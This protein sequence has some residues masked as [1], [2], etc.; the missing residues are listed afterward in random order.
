MSGYIPTRLAEEVR[1]RAGNV[2]EYCRLPQDIQEASFHVDHIQPR[3]RGGPTVAEN[4]A[5]ACV[6]CSLRK[7]AREDGDDLR[8]G[9]SSPLFHPR[10]DAWVEHFAF[11]S[12][13]KI[14]GRTPVGRATVDA[15]GMNRPAAVA[16]R[17]EL[18]SLGRFP[19]D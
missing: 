5:L 15:L 4:L 18:A 16:I 1:Q 19:P 6:S 11:T 3:A 9:K 2:C 14:R 12:R 7:S 13:W 10:Q 8:T 17:T